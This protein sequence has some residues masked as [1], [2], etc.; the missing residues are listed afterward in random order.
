MTMAGIL[1]FLKNLRLSLSQ[2]TIVTLA[3]VVGA[4]VLKL[5][6]QG[7]TVHKLQVQLLEQT[8]KTTLN[9]DD[10]AVAAAKTKFQQEKAAYEKAQE[11]R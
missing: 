2:W 11:E 4:L 5:E 7:G 9:A 3:G 10:A 1:N 8:T 6:L